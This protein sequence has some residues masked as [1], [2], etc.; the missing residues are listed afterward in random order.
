MIG[1][2]IV[3]H[4]ADVARGVPKII[5]QVAPD[6][7]VTFTGGTA[8][9]IGTNF[10]DILA[11][12]EANAADELLAFY[13]LGSAKMNLDMADEMTTKE[14]TIIDAPLVEGS[15]GAA[16]LLQIDTSKEDILAQLAPITF[17]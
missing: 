4:S 11:A 17:K 2:I 3:S 10:E 12:I 15:Y 7:P 5:A 6:V 8:D 14:I 1:L 16:T 13:D 9:G